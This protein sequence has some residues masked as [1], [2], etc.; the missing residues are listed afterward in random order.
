MVN[1]VVKYGLVAAVCILPTL[2]D[3]APA[4]A[5]SWGKKMNNGKVCRVLLGTHMH[6]G[7]SG[8]QSTKAVARASAIKRW[9]GFTAWEY[10]KAWSNFSLARSKSFTCSKT[11]RGEGWRCMVVAQPCKS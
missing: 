3:S 4:K 6:H 1:R 9:S 10:G 5:V 11:E 8:V 7:F 2:F